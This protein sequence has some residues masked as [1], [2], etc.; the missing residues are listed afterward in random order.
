MIGR[1]MSDQSLTAIVPRHE[2]WPLARILRDF[3]PGLEVDD[4]TWD[5]VHHRMWNDPEHAAK[6]QAIADSLV[7]EG[8]RRPINLGTDGRVWDG[9]HRIAAAMRLVFDTLMVT[10]WDVPDSGSYTQETQ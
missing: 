10:R 8:Q 4:W 6:T 2:R 3:R 1:M 7:E 5:D 9:H